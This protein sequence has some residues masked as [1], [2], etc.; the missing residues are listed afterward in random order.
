MVEKMVFETLVTDLLNKVLG[1]HVENLDRSQL[2]LGI[3]GGDVVLR[4]LKLKKNALD[5][6]DLP[7]RVSHG[8]L[9]NK[10]APYRV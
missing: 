2:K 6:L 4:N 9:G 1:D 7:V 8:F 10:L 3:W 5:D